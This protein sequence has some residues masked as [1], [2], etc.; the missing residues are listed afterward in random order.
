MKSRHRLVVLTFTLSFQTA[1]VPA[2]LDKYR[3]EEVRSS[4]SR[5]GVA[6]AES[7]PNPSSSPSSSSPS[8]RSAR[9][10]PTI[11][12]IGDG[13]FR[14][15]MSYERAWDTMVDVLLRNYNLQ[16][17]DKNSGILTTEWDSYYLDGK[18]HRNKVSLRLKKIGNQGIDLTVHNNVEILSR[19]QDG[20][21]EV[22]LPSDR[23]KPEIARIVQNL[24]IASG[25]P[26]PK[27]AADLVPSG[28]APKPS[29]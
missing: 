2:F 16:I 15:P 24:A 17:V 19:V 12:Q 9:T 26:K 10:P 3:H 6:R 7:S 18:V 1:C 23:N 25:Q 21:S 20:V 29:M 5:P 27:L 11:T 14:V 4:K 13:L 22:W 8:A 28:E